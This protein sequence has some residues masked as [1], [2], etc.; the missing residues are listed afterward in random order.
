VRRGAGDAT[1]AAGK[2]AALSIG[3][4]PKALLNASSPNAQALGCQPSV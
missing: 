4:P 2:D 1:L 3:E